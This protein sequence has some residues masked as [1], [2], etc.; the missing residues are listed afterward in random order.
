MGKIASVKPILG[1]RCGRF[2]FETTVMEGDAFCYVCNCWTSVAQ[3]RR[4]SAPSAAPAAREGVGV[5]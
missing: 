3:A 1:R 4:G 5:R 2:L